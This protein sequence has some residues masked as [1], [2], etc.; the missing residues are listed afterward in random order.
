MFASV[1]AVSVS[2]RAKERFGAVHVE[3]K[4]P[5]SAY[6]L[7]L[8]RKRRHWEAESGS[9]RPLDHRLPA[10]WQEMNAEDRKVYEI[11]ASNLQA[12]YEQQ[13]IEYRAH[14]RYRV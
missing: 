12:T 11:E 4:R 1:E 2:P 14:G 13:L 7:F 6:F 8:S 10:E 9:A 3:P 5:P